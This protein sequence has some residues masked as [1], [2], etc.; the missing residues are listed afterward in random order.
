MWKLKSPICNFLRSN[1]SSRLIHLRKVNITSVTQNKSLEEVTTNHKKSRDIPFLF[2][3]HT[4]NKPYF[5]HPSS[6][7][8]PKIFD[9]YKWL[10]KTVSSIG[11][12][13][14][15]SLTEEDPSSIFVREFE[16]SLFQTVAY[17]KS[18]ANKNLR[19]LIPERID[20]LV[21]NFIRLSL[22]EG[23]LKSHLKP[24]NSYLYHNP[25][26]ETHW[27]RNYKF[28][29]SKFQPNCVLRTKNNFSIVEAPKELSISEVDSLPGPYDTYSMNVYPRP[30]VHLNYRPGT[31][32]H[33][34]NYNRHC[35]TSIVFNNR[36]KFDDQMYTF[37]MFTMFAQ[38]SAQ[39]LAE[40]VLHGTD[41]VKPLV[42]QCVVT[43]GHRVTFML[44][45]L[46]TMN[47]MDD[48]GCWNRTWY[49]P[50]ENMYD[51]SDSLPLVFETADRGEVLKGF[52]KNFCKM[53]TNIIRKETL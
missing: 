13:E 5:V 33:K 3:P 26:V 21:F 39:A 1:E 18:Y 34:Y 19:R 53:F 25:V 24:E 17:Q 6:T 35:H 22:L 28:Y 29:Y 48:K 32:L 15:H 2:L 10:T 47:M 50:V 27:P 46:N 36:L 42:T 11:L 30:V 43:N 51:S 7:S 16:R 12:P 4:V 44:Y 41:L 20:G 40:G 37:G 45:Q 8:V 9:K 52:N 38:L 49:T 14:T 23:S 31:D